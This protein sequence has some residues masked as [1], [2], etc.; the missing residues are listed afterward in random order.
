MWSFNNKKYMIFRSNNVG[1]DNFVEFR[2]PKWIIVFFRY[3]HNDSVAGSVL[4]I[5]NIPFI[6]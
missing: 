5:L 1:K 6:V 2:Q 4:A 3:S